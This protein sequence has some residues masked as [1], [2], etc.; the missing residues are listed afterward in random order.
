MSPETT[1]SKGYFLIVLGFMFVF[2]ALS[3][4]I[5]WMLN[6][7]QSVTIALT[8]KWFIFWG[9]GWRLFTAGLRQVIKPAF[10]A[11]TIFNM[12]HEES[13]A[14]V[15]ELGYANICAGI[16]GILSLFFPAWR[17]PSA[18]GSGLF[19]GIAGINH[20]IRK[21]ANPNEKLA[22]ISDLFMFLVLLIF[23][24]CTI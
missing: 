24:I 2:P 16:I 10:T 14:I 6:N 1:L 21:P 15:K 23:V 17:V 9:I 20:L 11:K 22:L 18:V 13:Q 7:G 19:Y 8:G 3:V 5:E 4:F 12:Q